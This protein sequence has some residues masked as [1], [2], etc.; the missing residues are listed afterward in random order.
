MSE[1]EMDGGYVLTLRIHYET[2]FGEYLC[3]VGDIE[4]LGKWKE[5]TCQ[6]QW[7]EGHYWVTPRPIRVRRQFFQYKYLVL[8]QSD[9]PKV[10]ESGFNRV[11]DLK[12]LAE[13]SGVL[14]YAELG[15][16]CSLELTDIW[17]SFSITFQLIFRGSH[18]SDQVYLE[19]LKQEPVMLT[20]QEV[21]AEWQRAKYGDSAELFQADV[22]M[23]QQ[24]V[25]AHGEAGTALLNA[26][27][28]KPILLTYRYVLKH[29]Q[30]DLRQVEVRERDSVFRAILFNQPEDYK[31]EQPSLRAAHEKRDDR[32]FVVNGKA[33]RFDGAFKRPFSVHRL[34]RTAIFCGSFPETEEDMLCLQDLG[35]TAV[36]CIQTP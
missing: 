28:S 29:Q 26:E 12:L 18:D 9:V 11:V 15:K 32:L 2:K 3:V 24:E 36:M 22:L 30:K 20:K 27:V 5:F 10:W 6:L 13:K 25:K 16:A 4:E 34:D 7:T 14:D 31:G 1:E 21:L 33:A 8:H 19:G 35:V 23:S 17:N